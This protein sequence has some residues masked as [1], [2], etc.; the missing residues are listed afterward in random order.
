MLRE[1]IKLAW[2]IEART[3]DIGQNIRLDIFSA[4]DF[5]CDR[6]TALPSFL[7][8]IVNESGCLLSL[9][10]GLSTIA[11]FRPAASRAASGMRM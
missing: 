11:R 7:R 5:A 4:V 9:K 10:L 8:G 1:G 3:G 2:V 6:A